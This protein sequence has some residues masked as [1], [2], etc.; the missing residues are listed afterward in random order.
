MRISRKITRKRHQDAGR[1]EA[2]LQ[3]MMLL[4][5]KLQRIERAV[6]RCQRFDRRDGAA[7]SLHGERQAGA[8]RHVVDQYGAAAA[9]A[10]LTAHMGAGGPDNIAQ[11]IGEQHAGLG[12]ARH[13]AAVEGE[14][15]PRPLVLVYAAHRKASSTTMG[16]TRRSRS[17]RSRAD[18]WIS[19]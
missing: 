4:E 8:H 11:E 3:G 6:R 9:H 15:D 12:I 14:T 2:A 1:A 17:R 16:P 7:F 5:C 18:A 10:V 19:S 13:R